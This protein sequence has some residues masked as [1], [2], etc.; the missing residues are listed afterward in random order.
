VLNSRLRRLCPHLLPPAAL[1]ASLLYRFSKLFVLGQGV[2][3]SAC[4]SDSKSA[5]RHRRDPG[6]FASY[7]LHQLHSPRLS[8]HAPAEVFLGPA[9]IFGRP[10]PPE[11][12]A[13]AHQAGL[14]SSSSAARPRA[15][16]EA[17]PQR[18]PSWWDEKNLNTGQQNGGAGSLAEGCPLGAR[19]IPGSGEN[20][21]R[22]PGR[23]TIFLLW[24]F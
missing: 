7:N 23:S 13:T 20:P 11:S 1:V 2:Y 17:A 5:V 12:G 22:N 18:L 4:A 24:R 19:E 16:G 6:L 10:P 21:P 3:A 15:G 9:E 8:L 14:R